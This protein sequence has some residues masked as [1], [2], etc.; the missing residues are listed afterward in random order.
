MATSRQPTIENEAPFRCRV[1]ATG[2]RHADVT[3]IG[4]LDLANAP[5]LRTELL[6][7]LAA[8]CDHLTIDLGRLTFLDSSGMGVLVVV[9]K[10]AIESGGFVHLVSVP[11]RVRQVLD[12]CGLTELFELDPA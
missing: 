12:R 11:A 1:V 7:G 6:A 2:A 5:L 8:G 4:E 3:M 9:R 10:R